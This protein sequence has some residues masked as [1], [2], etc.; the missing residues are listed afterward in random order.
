VAL[1]EE[2]YHWVVGSSSSLSELEVQ[3]AQAI[4]LPV[5]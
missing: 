5:A 2:M 1:L 4:S 3:E